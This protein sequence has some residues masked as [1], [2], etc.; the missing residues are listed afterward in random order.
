VTPR[1]C[2]P[3]ALS[4]AGDVSGGGWVG[5][6][7]V[8]LDP[9]VMFDCDPT[10]RVLGIEMLEGRSRTDNPRKMTFEMTGQ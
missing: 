1:P 2:D 8:A 6:V 4:A 3:T 7:R 9:A 10:G 5:D